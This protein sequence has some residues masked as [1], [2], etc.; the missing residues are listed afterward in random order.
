MGGLTMAGKGNLNINS[1]A[2]ELGRRVNPQN[3]KT[4]EPFQSL[5]P[6][7]E[8][9]LALMVESMK[10]EGF[11][12]CYPILIWREEGVVIDGHT[13]LEA[14]RQAGLLEVIAYEISFNSEAAAIK[15]A[16]DAQIVRR[17]LT[18]AELLDLLPHYDSL[19]TT[20]AKKAG[21]EAKGKSAER[22]AEA[23]GISRAKVEQVR[24][25]EKEAS[26]EQKEEIKS[27]EK[28]I[29]QVYKEIKAE[30]QADMPAPVE[31]EPEQ[32]AEVIKPPQLFTQKECEASKA[33]NEEKI[34]VITSSL[35]AIENLRSGEIMITALAS[36]GHVPVM[37]INRKAF[38]D[39]DAAE[40]FLNEL[41][42]QLA[43]F[44]SFN[45]FK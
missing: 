26:E 33:K 19:D 30:S 42:E 32:A 12:G 27:G 9:V 31:S 14:A 15:Y 16:Q 25:V 3:L 4:A 1:A 37:A 28:S 43:L 5:F 13:R 44:D 8:H 36:K 11:K 34:H 21:E 39:N 17:N 22:T 18:D 38:A 24:R 6:I 45:S 2:R 40:N 29:N 7:K 41:Y 20:G 23:L 35:T 10:K